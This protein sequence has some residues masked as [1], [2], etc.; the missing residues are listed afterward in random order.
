[1][2]NDILGV[3]V[4]VREKSIG[5]HNRLLGE[6]DC[7]VGQV[8]QIDNLGGVG[9]CQKYNRGIK[10]LLQAY[11]SE[12]WIVFCHDDVTL[13]CSY[14]TLMQQLQKA[15]TSSFDIVAV[16]GN[17]AVPPLNPGYWWYGI[18][19]ANFRGAG[20]VT[21]KTPGKN[22]L[23]HVESYGPF[24]QQIAAFDGLWFAVR[25]ELFR[26]GT[27]RFDESFAGYHYYD[28]DFAATARA[29]GLS[30]GAMGIPVTHQQNGR[31]IT[32]P[33]FIKYQN[34][35]IGKWAR[36]PEEYKRF[37]KPEVTADFLLKTT[38]FKR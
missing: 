32:D 6:Y 2:I 31:G 5:L 20:A 19:S 14:T 15:R 12:G 22:D 38:A 30:I 16:A 1:M 4:G 17:T 23:Y 29:R 34:Q 3:V 13:D 11:A 25:S 36:R 9:L 33:D 10:S 27:F 18:T 28:A 24:P 21:H 8:V 7:A 35:F 26:D 37:A